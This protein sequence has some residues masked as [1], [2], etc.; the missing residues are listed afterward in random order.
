M[1]SDYHSHFKKLF[2]RQLPVSIRQLAQRVVF[3]DRFA[4]GDSCRE[5]RHGINRPAR[6]SI[7]VTAAGA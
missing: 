3:E 7:P 2:G 6:G 4:A 1:V 5:Y